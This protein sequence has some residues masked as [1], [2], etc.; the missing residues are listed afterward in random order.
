MRRSDGFFFMPTLFRAQNGAGEGVAQSC[1]PEGLVAS[2]EQA[3]PEGEGQAGDD[4]RS[5]A[6]IQ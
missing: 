1:S 3:L 4:A 6:G 5:L 2:C